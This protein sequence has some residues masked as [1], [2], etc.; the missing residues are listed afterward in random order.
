MRY[1]TNRYLDIY[2]LIT[3]ETI[4]IKKYTLK[5]LTKVGAFV[6]EH[7]IYRLDFHVDEYFILRMKNQHCDIMKY[8]NFLFLV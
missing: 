1:Q 5:R 4:E 7:L 3:K 2:S 8:F 6:F